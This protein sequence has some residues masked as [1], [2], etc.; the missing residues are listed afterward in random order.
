MIQRSKSPG[1]PLRALAAAALLLAAATGVRAEGFYIEAGP[2]TLHGQHIDTSHNP[3]GLA[4]GAGYQATPHLGARG[5]LIVDQFRHLFGPGAIQNFHEFVGAEA[6]ATTP[7]TAYF[8]LEG[9]LGAGCTHLNGG[10]PPSTRTLTE[11]IV[12]AGIG[13]RA[14]D[15]FA[16]ALRYDWLTHTGT[17]AVTLVFNVPF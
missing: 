12:S 2:S 5:V 3:F 8:D 14:S 11:G 4:L 16:M 10:D 15:H 7:I 1:A 17:S 6:T 13:H 9:A